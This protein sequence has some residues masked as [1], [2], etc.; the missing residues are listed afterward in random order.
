MAFDTFENNVLIITGAS[1]GIGEELALQLAPRKARLVL[2][3]RN[4]E[5][6]ER[7]ASKISALVETG[8]ARD[9]A[10][11]IDVGSTGAL[12]M[13]YEE[14]L[15]DYDGAPAEWVDG[16]VVLMAA[17]G[18]PHQIVTTFLLPLFRHFVED[19]DAGKVLCEPFQMKTGK[20]LPGRSPD[21]MF[22]ATEHVGR[23][24]HNHIDGPADLVV[25]VVSPG[26]R[27]RDR[28]EK[29]YEYE[30]GGVREYWLIDPIRQQAE[31][32]V[33]GEDGIY[34]LQQPDEEGLFHSVVLDG[35]W[36]EVGWL[37]QSPVPPLVEV[38]RAW[39]LV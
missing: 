38:L 1:S 11:D 28:G 9:T 5:K 21:L 30:A 29:Y 37:W 22:L 24:K 15:T 33:L 18:L 20:D 8:M 17:V 19:R 10:S 3:S 36:L 27:L 39:G 35:L 32:Y 6:L 14:F 26:S 34:Q 4:L 31:F 7:L 16:E 13:S 23:L 2:A 12:R 25:E